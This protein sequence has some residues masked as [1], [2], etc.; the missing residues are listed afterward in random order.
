MSGTVDDDYAGDVPARAT[1]DARATTSDA[2]LI[3]VRTRA[4]WTYV[5]IPTLE[6]IGKPVLLVAWDEFPTG[7]QVP[8]FVGR[9]EMA[10]SEHGVAN[11]APLYFLCRSGVRSRKAAILATAAGHGRCYNI[12]QGFEGRLG[13]DRHRATEGSWKAEGLPWIQS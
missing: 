3:D 12:E 10:L 1:W 6:A 5:G 4:E 8:D 7:D 9:L 11:D 2:T 13:P